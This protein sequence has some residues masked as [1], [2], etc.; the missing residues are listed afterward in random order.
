[1]IVTAKARKIGLA[2]GVLA[3]GLLL[4][5]AIATYGVGLATEHQLARLA[6]TTGQD[7]EME[8]LEYRRGFRSSRAV[9]LLHPAGEPR[10]GWRLVHHIRHGPLPGLRNGTADPGSW[11]LLARISSQLQEVNGLP[12]DD[13]GPRAE[14][15]VPL[16]G[17][18]TTS[19]HWP[20]PTAA[21][22]AAAPA[23]HWQQLAGSFHYPLDFRSLQGELTLTDFTLRAPPLPPLA[24]ERLS[25]TFTWRRQPEQTGAG[26]SGEQRLRL[27]NLRAGETHYPEFL[28]AANWQRLDLPALRQLAAL[29]PRLGPALASHPRQ[30]PPPAAETLVT[31]LPRLLQ[32]APQLTIEQARLVS[33]AG[34]AEGQLRLAYR[35]RPD[36]K[37]PFHPLMLF[38]GLDCQLTASLP[39][40]LLPGGENSR[41]LAAL[42][43]RGYLEKANQQED[44]QQR[45][46]LDISYHQGELSINN[47]PAPLQALLALL[48]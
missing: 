48:R 7:W 16:N 5:L 36:D 45:L 14:T 27:A 18:V 37:R 23:V 34:T 9:T 42:R 19:W 35:Q 25:T 17:E 26:L 20:P 33:P 11:L 44:G 2:L 43:R 15:T 22:E 30:V 40:A 1:M 28:L 4:L 47:R 32:H 31:A 24:L 46:E 39:V 8:L 41:T 38:S 13:K 12:L 21:A 29:A 6:A 10:A 3:L